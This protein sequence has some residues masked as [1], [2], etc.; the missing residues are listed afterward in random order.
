VPTP[1]LSLV[2]TCGL[3]LEELL[4]SEIAA[5]GAVATARDKGAVTFAGSW[6]EVYRANWRLRTANRVL[7]ELA[8]WDAADGAALAAGARALV[9]GRL[10]PASA[11]L[12]IRAL[13]APD[14]SLA[15]AATST[16]SAVRDTRWAAL[17]VKDGLVDGQ[18]DLFGRRSFV[19]REDPDLPLRVRLHEDRATLL[20]DTSGEPLDRR[21][22]RAVSTGAPVREQLAAAVVLASGWD[23][24]GPVVDPMCGSATLLI[25]AAWWALGRAPG[26]LRPGFAYERFPG[27][28]RV[29]AAAVRAEPIPAPGPAVALFGNDRSAAALG[30]ARANLERAGLAGRH[31]L[32]RGEAAD[33][34]PPAGPGLVVVNPPYGE[35][36]EMDRP[37]WRAL[38]DL[39]KKRHRGYCA[40]VLAGG[41]GFGKHI[42]LKPRRRIPVWN[43]PLE[44][45]IL[46]FD[47]F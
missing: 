6:S 19:E 47:L 7:V 16:A 21:G 39:L 23:G 8:S 43:G 36:L 27:F 14:H 11:A 44:A 33:F 2:A 45:R 20:L 42:G 25:E 15:V 31:Q 28:D 22:Y 41:E 9:T 35:R 24:Q 4:E 18:R 34:Y 37:A 3:G 46:V 5:L 29:L 38:G 40:A 30:A 32:K 1:S 17:S 26:Q 13:F 10:A 12:D